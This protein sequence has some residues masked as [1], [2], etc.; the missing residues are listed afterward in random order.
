MSFFGYY[1]SRFFRTS[2]SHDPTRMRDDRQPIPRDPH[3]KVCSSHLATLETQA[4]LFDMSVNTTKDIHDNT[5]RA[6]R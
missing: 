4:E 6:P 5:T 2:I 3:R 1:Y